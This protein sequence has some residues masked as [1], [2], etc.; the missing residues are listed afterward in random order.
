MQIRKLILIVGC[1]IIAGCMLNRLLLFKAQ[2][3]HVDQYVRFDREGEL[4]FI[5]PVLQLSDLKYL[6]GVEPTKIIEQRS[7]RTVIYDFNR[8]D[9]PEYSFRYE[10]IFEDGLLAV[11]DYPDVFYKFISAS[12]TM[13]ALQSVGA[14]AVPRTQSEWAIQAGEANTSVQMPTKDDILAVFGPPSSVDTF[15]TSEYVIYEYSHPIQSGSQFISIA[16][17][18]SRFNQTIEESYIQLPGRRWS[19]TF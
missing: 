14:A 9:H 1:M 8:S 7:K 10:L 3:N 5:K 18:F 6:T 16:F 15:P 12:F 11:I 13:H 2:L 19:L 4:V 17:M